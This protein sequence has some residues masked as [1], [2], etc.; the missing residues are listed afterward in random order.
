MSDRSK[1]YFTDDMEK[2][3]GIQ[4]LVGLA[5]TKNIEIK[6]HHKEDLYHMDVAKFC[7]KLN[8]DQQ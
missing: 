2:S 6:A 3:A 1:R 4:A 5:T 8:I 7:S